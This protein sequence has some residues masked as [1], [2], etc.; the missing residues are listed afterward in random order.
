MIIDNSEVIGEE[1]TDKNVACFITP[2]TMT[3]KRHGMIKSNESE[4]MCIKWV[5]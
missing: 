4:W 2:H 3:T 5:Y 1:I